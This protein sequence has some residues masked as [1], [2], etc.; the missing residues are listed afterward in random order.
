MRRSDPNLPPQFL[1]QP[2]AVL[3]PPHNRSLSYNL[4]SK[5]RPTCKLWLRLF[6]SF[7]LSVPV[8][9]CCRRATSSQRLSTTI[10]WPLGA[11]QLWLVSTALL[12]FPPPLSLFFFSNLLTV[13][14]L[15]RSRLC[16]V[17]ATP[18]SSAAVLP[19]DS[20]RWQRPAGTQLNW[21][22]GTA[23]RAGARSR[24]AS[25]HRAAARCHLL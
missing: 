19:S 4:S 1:N 10:S 15:S 18:S 11:G 12:S 7:S 3:P 24:L 22:L 2:P 5:K 25:T 21:T 20:N 17:Q 13:S 23:V 9:C 8:V 14:S 6:H 16:C